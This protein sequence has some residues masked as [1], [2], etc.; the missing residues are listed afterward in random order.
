[1]LDFIPTY[2]WGVIGMFLILVPFGIFHLADELSNGQIYIEQDDPTWEDFRQGAFINTVLIA[3]STDVIL[4][5]VWLS[6]NA[7]RL[8]AGFPDEDDVYNADGVRV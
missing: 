7:L 2:Q 4:F 6:V 3:V 8:P 5:V 1:M